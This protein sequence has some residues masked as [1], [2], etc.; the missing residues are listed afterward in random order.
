MP[1]LVAAASA[2]MGLSV[3]VFAASLAND[4]ACASIAHSSLPFKLIQ[5]LL[6]ACFV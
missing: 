2:A 6:M 5:Q 1:Y 4:P 3:Y